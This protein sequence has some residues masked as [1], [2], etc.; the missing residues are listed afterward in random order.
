[1][2]ENNLDDIQ[3]NPTSS[4]LVS[5]EI[6][7][8]DGNVFMLLL[9]HG[10]AYQLSEDMKKAA[11]KA[12][13]IYENNGY[14]LAP[15]EP[16]CLCDLSISPTNWHWKCFVHKEEWRKRNWPGYETKEPGK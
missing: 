15:E 1:M 13:R 12:K 2:S 14:V 10:E 16:A 9:K 4:G 7:E 8:D 3:V 5:L 11:D 6:T